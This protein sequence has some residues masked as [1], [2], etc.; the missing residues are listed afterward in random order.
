MI[1]DYVTESQVWDFIEIRKPQITALI[2]P[3]NPW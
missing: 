1:D 3:K 2:K